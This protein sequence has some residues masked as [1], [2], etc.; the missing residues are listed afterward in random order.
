MD[1][2]S[3][4]VYRQYLHANHLRDSTNP[5]T[6]VFHTVKNV[7]V[8]STW[9][10]LM[11]GNKRPIS[12]IMVVYLASRTQPKIINFQ[13]QNALA[14][15][16]LHCLHVWDIQFFNF[17]MEGLRPRLWPPCSGL[18]LT[19]FFGFA[20]GKTIGKRLSSTCTPRFNG[21]T[22]LKSPKLLKPVR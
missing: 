20:C 15:A 9:S 3:G 4:K 7:T 5:Y 6:T 21:T 10:F 19:D 14:L 22:C 2:I 8:L 18:I 16:I 13:W 11:I 1:L 12:A 17:R